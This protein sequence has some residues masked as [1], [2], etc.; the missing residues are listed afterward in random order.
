MLKIARKLSQL[1]FAELMQVY[2]Q[3][4]LQGEQ[5]LYDYLRQDF[6]H[7]EGAFYA[8]WEE[9]GAY[10]SALRLE[11]FRDGLL[12]EGLET[13]SDRRKQGY[14]KMLLFQVL[15]MSEKPIYSHIHKKN[16]ASQAVHRA[17]GFVKIRNCA[18]YID[19]SADSQCD[20]WRFH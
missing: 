3:T 1:N 18:V 6:F 7:R 16:A 15:R 14:A 5:D 17:C 13:R 12:L 19:G 20:T 4:S 8:V 9:N 2:G 10:I 11:P